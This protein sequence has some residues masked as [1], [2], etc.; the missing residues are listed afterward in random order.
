ML[1]HFCSIVYVSLKGNAYF[2]S[3]SIN[4]F[5]VSDFPRII[6]IE[7]FFSSSSLLLYCFVIVILIF[8][9][10]E[11]L[12]VFVKHRLLGPISGF[13]TDQVCVCVRG[14]ALSIWV[15]KKSPVILMLL[16]YAYILRTTAPNHLNYISQNIL[17]RQNGV[18]KNV[19]CDR[20][21]KTWL[22]KNSFILM[23]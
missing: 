8:Q 13:L 3:Q 10:S 23:F 4:F 1:S 12:G 15:S 21:T 9:G 19:L 18:M 7:L 17:L 2:C 14:A 11:S 20:N 16:I 5:S 6:L 22:K